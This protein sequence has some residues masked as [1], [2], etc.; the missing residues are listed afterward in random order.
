MD[1]YILVVDDEPHIR[2][3]LTL[4]LTRSGYDVDTAEDGQSAIERVREA[5]P[6]LVIADLQMPRVDGVELCEVLHSDARTASIPILLLTARGFELDEDDLAGRYP[7]V[8][9]LCKPFSPFELKTLVDR[10]LSE[11]SQAR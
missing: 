8:G 11:R 4:Q 2:R 9:I 1:D 5:P 7:I 10:Q 6:L 3:I